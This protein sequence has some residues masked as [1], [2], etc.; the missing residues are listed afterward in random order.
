MEG[1]SNL[2]LPSPSKSTLFEKIEWE[3]RKDNVDSGEDEDL[4]YLD[5][6][7]STFEEEEE[8]EE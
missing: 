1:K 6:E 3:E 8:E 7:N 2:N 5:N 4:R